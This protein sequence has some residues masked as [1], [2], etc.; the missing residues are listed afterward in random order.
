MSRS[1]VVGLV[2]GALNAVVAIATLAL[3]NAVTPDNFGW[4]AYA[5][6]NEDVVRDPRFPWQYVAVPVALIVV[7]VLAVPFL[8]RRSD[9]SA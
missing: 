1:L 5:P 9:S 2:F 3:V 7:N 8:L 4:F 6:L